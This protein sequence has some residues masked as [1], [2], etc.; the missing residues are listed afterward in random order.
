MTGLLDQLEAARGAHA[1]AALQLADAWRQDTDLRLGA[2]AAQDV[3]HSILADPGLGSQNRAG[4]DFVDNGAANRVLASVQELLARRLALVGKRDFRVRLQQRAERQY[5]PLV[6]RWAR[7]RPDSYPPS[8]Y[9]EILRHQEEEVWLANQDLAKDEAETGS[10]PTLWGRLVDARIAVAMASRPGFSPEAER[11]LGNAYRDLAAVESAKPAILARIDGL[12]TEVRETYVA[13]QLLE[14]WEPVIQA[15]LATLDDAPAQ[16]AGASD[17]PPAPASPAAPLVPA[18]AGATSARLSEFWYVTA[19]GAALS[20]GELGMTLNFLN[21]G[22]ITGTVRG[23][24][25]VRGRWSGGTA[26]GEIT[27]MPRGRVAHFRFTG[28][29]LQSS[30]A[31]GVLQSDGL[32]C[33]NETGLSE[34]EQASGRYRF[35]GYILAPGS[36]ANP[37]P[38]MEALRLCDSPWRP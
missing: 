6:E 21:D 17:A 30:S 26:E 22:S 12:R 28:L 3:I 20:A 14:A 34:D 37:T 36:P 27:G 29:R 9:D 4:R 25:Q 15:C 7:T 2:L 18:G 31:S 5:R 10:L 11:R 24:A 33:A 35:W 16:V 1:V 19:D 32:W 23:G 38:P 13:W 8:I